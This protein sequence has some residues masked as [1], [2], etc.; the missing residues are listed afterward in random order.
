MIIYWTLFLYPSLVALSP[1]KTNHQLRQLNFLIFCIFSILVIGFRY[2][3]GG[4][5]NSYLTM[6]DA[7]SDVSLAKA[8]VVSD[9][10]YMA[11]NWL[12]TQLGLGIVGVNLACGIL[13]MNGLLRLC[14]KQ[15]FPWI[16]LAIAVPYLVIV[17]AMGYSR[18][19]VA[20]GFV[21][22]A[23]SQWQTGRFYRCAALVLIGALFHKSAVVVLPLLFLMSGQLNW[24]FILKW[25]FALPVLFIVAIF[26]V[27]PSFDAKWMSYVEK[28]IVHSEGGMIRVLMNAIPALLFFIMH[29][30][31][32]QY[33]DY[34]LLVLLALTSIACVPFVTIVSTLV[35]RLALFLIPIQILVIPR[36]LHF[37]RNPSTRVFLAIN[38]LIL[39]GM[40]LFVWLTFASHREYWLPFR[41]SVFQ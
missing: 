8:I 31:F 34:R 32:K 17:V 3:I 1:F 37:F 11:L 39:Y 40:V 13:F 18:Q 33:Q 6:L 9:P 14:L 29:K 36:I 5:W 30:K 38:V 21:S 7:T 27:M 24:R 26:L 22:W 35:D 20:I 41:W 16:G 2:E 23:L 25:I 12:S 15:P 10:G 28:S 19:A 4:D